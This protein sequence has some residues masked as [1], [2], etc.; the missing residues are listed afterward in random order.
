MKNELMGLTCSKFKSNM[1]TALRS[2]ARVVSILPFSF[3]NSQIIKVLL[4]K[5]CFWSTSNETAGSKQTAQKPQPPPSD[6]KK[7]V[8]HISSSS[9]A[10]QTPKVSLKF[11]SKII[12]NW[13]LWWKGRICLFK[14]VYLWRLQ[15]LLLIQSVMRVTEPR[16]SDNQSVSRQDFKNPNKHHSKPIDPVWCSN[17]Y[18]LDIKIQEVVGITVLALNFIG[19]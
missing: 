18:F 4:T 19:R 7:N 2:W 16:W 6:E 3:P 12:A 17:G 8:R 1:P 9:K 10:S 5:P 13:S 11:K 14:L 15:S